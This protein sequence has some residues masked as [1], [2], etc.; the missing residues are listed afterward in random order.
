MLPFKEVP[1][2]EAEFNEFGMYAGQG[3]QLLGFSDEADP[4]ETVVA[5]I[6]RF[7]E[8][9]DP[10]YVTG[11]SE[12]AIIALC[13]GLVWGHQVTRALDW[14][15]TVLEQDGQ[16]SYAVVSPDR[17]YATHPAVF[18]AQCLQG[19]RENTAVLLFN[20]LRAGNLPS[21]EPNAYLGLS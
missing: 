16:R 18:I 13:I 20:L 15:W 19:V 5:A 10:A 17:A 12:F 9:W 8:E 1:L 21:S 14:Q 11:E 3:M 7:I 4:P 2:T 6:G